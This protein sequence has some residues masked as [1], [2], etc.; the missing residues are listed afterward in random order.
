[1]D[2]SFPKTVI[3]FPFHNIKSCFIRLGHVPQ[4]KTGKHC[5]G[6]GL[7]KCTSLPVPARPHS[8]EVEENGSTVY[9]VAPAFDSALHHHFLL[10]G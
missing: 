6:E 4:E 10:L 1:M 3:F 9:G 5:S 2:R 7:L 8:E